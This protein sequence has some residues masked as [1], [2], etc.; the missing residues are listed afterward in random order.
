MPDNDPGQILSEH[1]YKAC[2]KLKSGK[3]GSD[4]ISKEHLVYA[5]PE[6]YDRLAEIFNGMVQHGIVPI[7][8]HEGNIIPI[9]KN[10]KGD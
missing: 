7:T 8:F 9:P 1:V 3:S 4:R 10:V 5:H 6:I 2:K